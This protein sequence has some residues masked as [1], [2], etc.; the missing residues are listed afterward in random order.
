MATFT[1][2][3]WSP[4]CNQVQPRVQVN[5]CTKLEEFQQRFS[6]EMTWT[7]GIKIRGMEP[8][9]TRK[10]EDWKHSSTSAVNIRCTKSSTQNSQWNWLADRRKN[11]LFSLWI[12]AIWEDGIDG[13]R[14][15]RSTHWHEKGSS[16]KLRRSFSVTTLITSM[17][18]KW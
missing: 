18:E 11:W 5:I 6:Q 7:D 12:S 13:N 1:F 15:N 14:W 9:E 8:W 10:K 3:P 4:R 2:E 17:G 16:P